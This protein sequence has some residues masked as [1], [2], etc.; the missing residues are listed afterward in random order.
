[1]TGEAL[2]VLLYVLPGKLFSGQVQAMSEFFGD[3]TWVIVGLL[4]VVVL[5]WS[6]FKS[7][8]S[9]ADAPG[10]KTYR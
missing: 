9:L 3:F 8:R 2:W 6:L 4:V 10:S 5:G 1:V 7:F